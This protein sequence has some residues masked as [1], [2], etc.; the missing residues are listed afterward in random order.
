MTTTHL[1]PLRSSLQ[2]Q[3]QTLPAQFHARTTARIAFE[4]TGETTQ[5]QTMTFQSLSPETRGTSRDRQF[6][7]CHQNE[8]GSN[9]EEMWKPGYHTEGSAGKHSLAR[10]A[11]LAS[12]LL[13]VVLEK[14]EYTSLDA[15]ATS[16]IERPWIDPEADQ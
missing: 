1:L 15:F 4:R 14:G 5:K 8:E 16:L 7:Q 10:F 2:Q 13:R 11:R 3:F 6:W 9:A 12:L